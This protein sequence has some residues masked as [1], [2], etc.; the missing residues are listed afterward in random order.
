MSFRRRADRPALEVR[1]AGR[2]R[3]RLVTALEPNE[4]VGSRA[5]QGEEILRVEGLVKHFPI[6]A[7]IL[8]RTVGQIHA[9]DGVDL[10]ITAG[11]T[12]G[13]VGESGCGKTTLS[14]TIIKLVE[15]T[16][17]KIIFNGRDITPFSRRQMRDVR[18]EMQIVFQDPYASLNPRMTVRDIVGEPLRI[19]GN[20][21]GNQGKQ[22][23][24]ELLRTVGLSPEHANRFP[25]EFSGGQRQRI[26][27]ARALALNP[28][29]TILDEPVSA[30]DVSIRAQVVNLLES[31]QRDF[32]LTYIF[33]A[34][35][36]SV[37]RHV[38]DRVPLR[39]GGQAARSASG[40]RAGRRA[41]RDRLAQDA[42]ASG[43]AAT[44]AASAVSAVS[45]ARDP[46][47]RCARSDSFAARTSSSC[48]TQYVLSV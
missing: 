40:F 21:R 24:N 13:L 44:S 46:S 16:S 43:V 33:V 29:L 2:R 38:S 11:E 3:R 45:A 17:G 1:R 36:L 32:G 25:H 4:L 28:Q 15:P 19:H 35:D 42:A 30:L 47:T 18:R 9:V 23:V 48:S 10:S 22:R 39:R 5:S 7:G 26:G 12:V 41:H 8:K 6:R 31:L 34:H 14:R 20:Y 37:V 27:V